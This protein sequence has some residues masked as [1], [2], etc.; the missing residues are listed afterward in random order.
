MRTEHTSVCPLDCPD[1]CS[2]SVAVEDD[3]IVEVRGS[4]ANPYTAGVICAKVARDFPPI[5]NGEGRLLTPLRRIGQK[6]EGRFERISWEE[7]LDSIHA[8]F[9][10]V[11]ARYG[12]QAILPLSYAG[13]H[14]MLAC[15]SMDLRFFHKLGA[16]LLDRK[17]LCGGI[18]T[19]AWL[20]TFGPVPGI[21]PEQV[22]LS[23]LIIAWGNNV[24]WSNLHL[25][26]VINRARR[27]GARLVV[28]DPKRTKVAEQA[29]LH[30]ALRPGTDVVL[31]WAITNELERLGG[32]D[33]AFIE[34]HVEG[35][36]AYME[37]VRRITLAEAERITGVPSGEI[38]KL[39]DWYRALSPAAISVGNGLE[40]NQNGGSGIRAIFALPALAGKL[41]VPGGG[42]V[43][44]AS[45]AFPKTTARLQRPD[46]V[47]EGTRTL[48]IIDVGAHLLDPAL[49]PPVKAVFVYNHNPVI[50]HPDQNRLRRGLLREDLFVAGSDVV[51]TDSM[52]HCDI[53]LPASSHFE[54]DDL[55][56]AY[57]QHWLQRALPVIRPRGESLPNTEIFRRL[58]ARFGFDGP[59]FEA[60]DAELMDDAMDA[61]DPRLG[62]MRPSRLPTDRALAMAIQGEEAVLFKNVFPR[63]P[64]GKVELA[65]TY[66][67]DKYGQLLPDYRPY[68]SSYPLV[69]ISPASDQRIT[70]T[71]GGLKASHHAP[72]LQM[73]PEDAR[74]RGLSDGVT[75]KIWN[76]LGEIHLPLEITEA[77]RPG[78]VSTL[79]GAWLRTSDNGQTVSALCPG[80]HADISG[81]ACFNDTRVEVAAHRGGER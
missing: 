2:L 52:A 33:R 60:T 53:V 54:Y 44:G 12:P 13:P 74:A 40:R 39:A 73:H 48:N 64:S 10:A 58:A 56:P 75:V 8:R 50:V 62:G 47:P 69:L 78:V 55:Y 24:T 6:G 45:F 29:D 35:F 68:E 34:R 19:E 70:S 76:D 41:G 77:V 26:P 28:V 67:E 49:S 20:G 30:V 25:M 61:T 81:G 18:R 3:R 43:N 65:S 51:M 57:G 21:P 80:H 32:L 59:I 4:R 66:L 72:P 37:R 22:A 27:R 9:T 1:T 23:R 42:L 7:A 63:T 16:T 5:A 14:G 71:F 31:A 38:Q 11:I 17:P 79:K 15:G 46:L 36:E